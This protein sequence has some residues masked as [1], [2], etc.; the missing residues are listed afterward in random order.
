MSIN[1]EK[2]TDKAKE[3]INN[4]S[5]L[6]IKNGHQ[7]IGCEHIL[8]T[9]LDQGG[10][11]SDI[12][13][14]C[15]SNIALV[16]DKVKEVVDSNPV[17]S[18]NAS[19]PYLSREASNALIK[20]QEFGKEYND[21]YIGQDRIL[22]GIIASK[23]RLSD[24]LIKIGITELKIRNAIVSIRNGNN[25]TSSDAEGTYKTLS[26][27]TRDITELAR[28][29]KIDPVIGRDTEIRRAI[30]ILTRRSK[31]NPILIGEP[32]VGKTAIAE[33]LALRIHNGDVPENIK[34]KKI[35]EL[36]MGLI[37]A[38]AKYKGE[39]EERFK[40]VIN[41]VERSDGKIILFIDEVHI[42]MGAGSGGGAMDA[43]NLIKPALARGQMKCIGATTLN[44]YK[45]YIEKDRAFARRFQAVYINEPTVDDAITIL[46]G[47]K[48][49]YELYHGVRVTDSAIITSVTMSHKYITDRYLPDKAIDLM[50]EAA[51]ML[52]MQINSKPE[53]ID[54]MERQLQH[55]KVEKEALKKEDDEASKKRL[56]ELESQIIKM[57]KD[58]DDALNKWNAERSKIVKIKDMKKELE[59]KKFELDNAQR[60]GDLA[61]AGE[62]MYGVIPQLEEKIKEMD[63]SV[64]ESQNSLIRETV[65]S[66]DIAL[67]VSRATGIPVEKMLGS[68]KQKLL[69]I[70]KDIKT[71]V[72]GQDHAIE[73]VANAI[74]RSRAGLSSEN[75]PIGSFLFLGPTGVGK[76]E[77]TKAIAEFLFDDE[78][79]M[80]RIDMSEY[81]EK[82]SISRLIGS[83]PGYVG[84]EE[85]GILTEA[86]RR[87]PYQVILF[88]EVEKAHHDVF[89]LLLQVLDDGRLTDSHGIT[90]D[91]QNTIIIMTS[92]LGA[93]FIGREK[94]EERMKD[95]V[96]NQ[97]R[98]FF[99][100]EFLNRL[101]DTVFFNRLAK[102][103]MV[104]IIDIQI[105][106]LIRKLAKQNIQFKIS[107]SAKTLIAEMGYDEVFGARPLKRVIQ[108]EIEN[109][110]SEYLLKGSIVPGD[111]IVVNIKDGAIVIGK[112]KQE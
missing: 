40:A 48:D 79:A 89:N 84:Y 56:V 42:L 65:T 107:E 59:S 73:V 97:V 62:L 88:D 105:K 29:G 20:A 64:D 16:K 13:S 68:E 67:V 24:E 95:E 54:I 28:Q 102:E 34:D 8:S 2:F 47:I 63:S 108:K 21:D 22:H 39:F 14:L 60:K 96:M 80:I 52:K 112:T 101:D 26:K 72:V 6:A 100:P 12:I 93:E 46:R 66:D 44:E 81:M 17:I 1:F 18:G 86:V 92:N 27:Y 76:T 33:G 98:Q 43:S 82:H 87:R 9:M 99:R 71:R 30:Q 106:S 32:G 35:L 15:D 110:L 104:G 94:N 51:S 103:N 5:A 91:F 45:K 75:K 69:Q 25:A 36:D 23:S 109:K 3:C 78:K 74:R 41:E 85:G 19:Q 55:L 31:N 58:L 61:K 83:P 10:I 70:E 11:I 50:D 4:A 77:L 90:V 111:S 38:G 7:Q 57:S 49:K 37:V 53:A